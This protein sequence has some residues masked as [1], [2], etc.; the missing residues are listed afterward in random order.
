MSGPPVNSTQRHTSF[1]FLI[2]CTV[3]LCSV[4]VRSVSFE[5]VECELTA[6]C[7]AMEIRRRLCGPND[8]SVMAELNELAR[9]L[10]TLGQYVIP[11]ALSFSKS[12]EHG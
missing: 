6:V 12:M 8:Q 11:L 4:T 5:E 9:G 10:I 3:V 7:Q 1:S 2:R